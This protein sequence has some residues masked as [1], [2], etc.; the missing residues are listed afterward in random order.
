MLLKTITELKRYVAIDTKGLLPSFELEL[1]DAEASQVA[2]LL[3][4]VLLAWLQAQY[5]A[6]DF[7]LEGTSLAAQL[8][9]LVQAPLARFATAS[10]IVV[11]QASIDDT[12]VH[13]ASNDTSKTA[14]QW[15]TNQRQALELGRCRPPPRAV[16]LHR[17]LSGVREHLQLAPGVL[18]LGAPAPQAG[19]A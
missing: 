19:G 10:G 12:G 8:V 17:R 14:F 7:D 16:Y 11:H 6:V 5:D 9:R 3:G 18:G 1:R 4:P 15:Q 2:P 13:I